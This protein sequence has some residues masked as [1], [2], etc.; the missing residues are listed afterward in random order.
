MHGLSSQAFHWTYT[1]VFGMVLVLAVYLILV[2]TKTA[3]T[4]EV[5][6]QFADIISDRGGVIIVLA[7]ISMFFFEQSMRLFYVLIDLISTKQ[8]DVQNGIALMAVQ[9]AS[10]SAFGMA[11]GAMLKTMNGN[12][13]PPPVIQAE[14]ASGTAAGRPAPALPAV[15]Q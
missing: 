9:F 5:V 11:F 3:P 15:K 1:G 10:N 12:A 8:I 7:I 14:K 6:R 13:P 2:L 4:I